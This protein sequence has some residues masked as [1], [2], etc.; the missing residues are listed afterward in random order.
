MV[1]VSKGDIAA[2]DRA[3]DSP[4]RAR[5]AGISGFRRS[6]QLG[7]AAATRKV[8]VAGNRGYRSHACRSSNVPAA[9]R[10]APVHSPQATHLAAAG[11]TMRGFY[12]EAPPDAGNAKREIA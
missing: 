3:L 11:A 7:G 1:A 6:D 12:D 10:V 5:A 2:L 8:S 9:T 4:R